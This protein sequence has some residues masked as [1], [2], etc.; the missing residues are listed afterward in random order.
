M[1]ELKTFEEVAKHM[2]LDSIQAK[3]YVK[4]MTTRWKA[5]ETL[6]CSTGYASE[7]AKRF[8]MGCEYGCSDEDGQKI[9]EQMED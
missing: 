2:K 1:G 7:W 3:R 8:S 9:L 6:M 4:Y 5:K